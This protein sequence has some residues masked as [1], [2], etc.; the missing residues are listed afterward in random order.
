MPLVA[1]VDSSTQST[2]VELRDLD[3]GVVMA[4]ASASHPPTVPPVSEQDPNAWWRALVEAMAQIEAPLRSQVAA[5]AVAAQQH[6]LVLVDAEGHPVR[7]AKLWNDTTAASVASEAVAACG[8]DR[9]AQ[10]C[11]SVPVAA[12][13]VAKVGWA[14]ANEPDSLAATDKVMLPHDYLTWRLTGHHVTDRGDASGTGWFDPV[15]NQYV[16]ELLG[17]V[18]PDPENWVE[19][20]PRVLGPF[21]AAGELTT[22]AAEALGLP[23]RTLVGPGTGDNMGAALGLGLASGDVVISLGTSGTVYAVSPVATH[24]PTGA[25]AGFA[26]AAGGFLPLLCT[27]NATGV[28]DTV[29]AWM[30][31]DPAGLS[32]LALNGDHSGEAPTLIPYFDGERTPNLPDAAG[33]WFG[34]RRITTRE[35]LARAAHDGVLCSLLEGVNR[36]RDAGVPVDNGSRLRLIGGGARSAAYRQRCADLYGAPITVPNADEAV[37]TGAAVQ[38]AV[39]ASGTDPQAFVAAW[40]LGDGEQVDPLDPRAGEVRDAY[41]YHQQRAGA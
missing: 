40:G 33:T 22:A 5:I 28:T 21:E 7:P 30:G 32:D 2:K 36:L 12:F 11:G 20:L 1:G 26:D 6:G 14:A 23:P 18:V 31:T 17:A 24:D 10:G 19:R 37:A 15:T 41:R 29:A 38:A 25:V 4:Q 35:Q 13:T 16:P 34:L 39:V 8:A 27:L 3:T 9:W